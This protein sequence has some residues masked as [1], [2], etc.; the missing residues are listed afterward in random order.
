MPGQFKRKCKKRM[1]STYAKS[2]PQHWFQAT[3]HVCQQRQCSHSSL[4]T[5]G[6]SQ[7]LYKLLQDD[8]FHAA[9]THV[10]NLFE[11]LCTS[12]NVMTKVLAACR[13]LSR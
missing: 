6:S 12:A 11:M 13:P 10:M 5:S 8:D 4:D 9:S 3:V 7:H 2:G 1:R